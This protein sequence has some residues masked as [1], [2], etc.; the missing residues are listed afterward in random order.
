M[1]KE[2]VITFSET[3][4]SDLKLYEWIMSHDDPEIFIKHMARDSMTKELLNKE[5]KIDSQDKKR[6]LRELMKS[7]IWD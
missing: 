4:E 7:D 6:R 2:L 1:N 3:R 5:K